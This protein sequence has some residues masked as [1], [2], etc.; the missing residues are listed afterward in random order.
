M[1]TTALLATI[2][3][4]KATIGHYQPLPEEEMRILVHQKKVEPV[5]SSNALEGNTLSLYETISVLETGLTP[6]GKPIKDVLEVLDLSDAYDYVMDLVQEKGPVAQTMI[7]DLNRLVTAKTTQ[8][9]RQAGNYRDIEVWPQGLPKN[10]YT[11]SVDIRPQMAQLVSW[12]K[13]NRNSMHPVLYAAELHRRFVSIHPFIDGN[14]RTARL[15][16]NFAL[17][18]NGWPLVNIRPDRVSRDKYMQALYHAQQTG[19]HDPFDF[20]VAQYVDKELD[21][22]IQV[23]KLHEQNIKDA[24]SQTNLPKDK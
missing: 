21:E 23:L 4:K 10:T 8:D 13:K 6:Q 20:L 7:R 18:E 19:D 16:M 22:G 3:A 2:D 9:V 12:S 15:L 11:E 24:E 14:G 17:L 1:D 5:W